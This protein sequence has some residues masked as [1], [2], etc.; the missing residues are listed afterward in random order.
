MFGPPK[1]KKDMV[2][3]LKKLPAFDGLSDYELIQVER[4]IHQRQYN[5]GEFVFEENVP[6]AGMYI[7]KKGEI[8]IKKKIDDSD[9][10]ITLASIKK[11]SF[12]GEMALIDEMPRSAAAVAKKDTELLAFCKPDLEGLMSRNPTAAVKIISNIAR[13]VCKR[14]VVTNDKLEEAERELLQLRDEGGNDD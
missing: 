10:E 6:G 1:E 7:I 4:V 14:L 13:L 5:A 9:E 8:L 11:D 2:E 12:F 3:L